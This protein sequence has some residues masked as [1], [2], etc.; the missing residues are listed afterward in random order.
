MGSKQLPALSVFLS[1]WDFETL[2]IDTLA[3]WFARISL[4]Y[5]LLLITQTVRLSL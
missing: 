4:G 2:C 3:I 5:D 1:L